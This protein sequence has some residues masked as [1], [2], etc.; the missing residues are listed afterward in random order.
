M[1]HVIMERTEVACETL[2]YNNTDASENSMDETNKPI[3]HS[4]HMH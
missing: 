3:N 1:C 2:L 4:A